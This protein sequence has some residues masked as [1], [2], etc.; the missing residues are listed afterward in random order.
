MLL[1]VTRLCETLGVEATVR[2]NSLG[3]RES[4][5][6]YRDSLIQYLKSRMGELCES[7]QGRVVVNPLRVLDCKRPQCQAVVADAPD[8]LDSL[9]R[10]ARAY[11][12]EVQRLLETARL[13]YVRDPRLVRGLDYYTGTVFELVA[14]GLGAQNAILGGGRYDGL[15][16]ELG[17]PPTPAVGFAAGIERLC[18]VVAPRLGGPPSQFGGP[19][20]YIAPM[21]GAETRAL[22]LADE[23][24][25][26][27]PW[28]VEVDV[29]GG[30]LKQQ[31]RRA[32]RAGARYALVIGEDELGTGT[33]K[34]KDL[35]AGL[36]QDGAL[37]MVELQG[38]AL[39]RALAAQT[40][41]F[42]TGARR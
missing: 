40:E 33:G 41:A 2:L 32:D 6:C 26:Q 31:L 22:A 15:V 17:G 12:N 16:S 20:L 27:G 9:S 14:S 25:K 11:F 28:R 18:L 34:L 30:R 19:H 23:V 1:M 39:A 8:I 38:E 36:H 24:R 7:C 10:P 35:R 29:S 37:G 3:D 21:P 5:A 42:P 4:R 13:P